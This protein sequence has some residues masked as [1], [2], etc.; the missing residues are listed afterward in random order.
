[1]TTE[2]TNGNAGPS[3]PGTWPQLNLPGA[4]GLL[5]DQQIKDAMA[6]GQLVRNG[7]DENAKYACYELRIGDRIEELVMDNNGD[8][9]QDI[10]R[11]KHIPEDGVFKIIPG[12]TFKIFAKETLNMPSNVTA[13]A[14]PVGNLYKLG[15]HPETTFADPGFQNEFYITVCNYSPRIVKLKVGEPLARLFF[16]HLNATPARRHSGNPRPMPPSVERVPR[17]T[18]E[19]LAAL[20]E[21][22][23]IGTVL[24][25]VDP[26]HYEH[27][28]VT[29]RV[30]V[31]HRKQVEDELNALRKEQVLFRS[32]IAVL[33]LTIASIAGV[34]IWEWTAGRWPS[35]VEGVGVSVVSAL[36]L[37]GLGWLL[38]RVIGW[39]SGKR[40]LK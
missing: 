33:G 31:E 1:V 27:A 26:P 12:Q 29:Q 37:A 22:D 4:T 6:T 15:V 40:T 5:I 14:F 2:P 17:R 11:S 30:A 19:E 18:P 28:F 13:F 35:L 34:M 38:A 8:E 3:D 7:I 10:Y 32:L 9:Q 39:L 25:S 24:S 16:F 20:Q 21:L 36:I 23:L